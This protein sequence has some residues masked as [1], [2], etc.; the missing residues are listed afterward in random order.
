MAVYG[1]KE[2]NIP[3]ADV[4]SSQGKKK[5]NNVSSLFKRNKHDLKVSAFPAVSLSLSISLPFLLFFSFLSNVRRVSSSFLYTE[6][7][8]P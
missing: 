2:D 4:V 7:P 5:S 3:V 1:D 6:L 8:L